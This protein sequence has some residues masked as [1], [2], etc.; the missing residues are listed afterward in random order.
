[1]VI[2]LLDKVELGGTVATGSIL[3]WMFLVIL[4]FIVLTIKQV[5]YRTTHSSRSSW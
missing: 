2:A 5:K 1:M 3:P 4:E